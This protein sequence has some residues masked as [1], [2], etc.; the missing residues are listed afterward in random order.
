MELFILDLGNRQTKLITD[1]V[2]EVLPSYFIDAE[3][4]GDRT[5]M[6]FAKAQTDTNDYTSSKDGLKYV[7][8]TEID[9]DYTDFITDTLAFGLQRYEAL[10]YKLLVDFSLAR[11][12]KGYPDAKKGTL[13]VS[14]VT[15]VPTKDHTNSKILDAVTA[16]IKGDHTVTVDG[17]KVNV[18][19]HDVYILPQS[20]GTVI[21]E[22]TND[23]GEVIE[24][25]ILETNVAVVDGGGG[26]L[27]VDILNK[28][29]VDTKK[30]KQSSHGA[31]V[32]Y[33]DI[34]N[35]IFAEYG[36]NVSEYEVERIV[37]MG[38]KD[39]Y[40]LSLDGI[41]DINVT[42]QV[43]KAREAYTRNIIKEVKSALKTTERISQILVTGGTAN[44]LIKNEF[45]KAFPNAKFV[46]NSEFA[47][48]RGFYKFAKAEGLI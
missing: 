21:N 35:R 20:L 25:A 22:V 3:N 44:L 13:D 16:A 11:L 9:L 34:V 37:R 43:M 46:E 23:D 18:R 27:L 45:T 28:M 40:T 42:E 47:N 38:N 17:E 7:W 29:N 41:D 39:T 32:L 14:V 4:F 24:S 36:H 2:E 48:A 12:A 19:V 33:E 30:R 15:G 8:G 10:D 26:T 31:Y 5:L 1:Q 6:N